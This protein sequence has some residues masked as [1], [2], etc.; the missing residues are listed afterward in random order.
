MEQIGKIKIINGKFNSKF[1]YCRTIFIDD[2]IKAMID[3]GAE[4]QILIEILRKNRIKYLF[5]THYHYDHIHYNYLFYRSK[6]YINKIEAECFIKPSNI[7]KRVGIYQVYGQKAIDDWLYH[8]R[9]INAQKT[10]YS[11]SRN[12]AWFL[13]TCRLDGTYNYNESWQCGETEFEF[14]H[15]PGH[16]G[17]FC[18]ILFPGEDLICTGDIDLTPFGPWYGGTDS[19]IDAFIASSQKIVDL[20]MKYYATG[21]DIGTLSY[22]EFVNKLEKYLKIIDKRDSKIFLALQS[23]PMTLEDLTKKGMIYGDPK[24]LIDPWVYAWEQLTLLK[25]L[26]RMEI[27]KKIFKNGNLFEIR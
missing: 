10:P 7:V 1:P 24:Y 9:Q 5:N 22:D 20:E 12:H 8:I 19:D 27:N 26:E 11:P 6:I 15:S 25:H 17:G 18:C 2:K 3:P 23:S 4:R 13:S 21:H 16:S 14:I